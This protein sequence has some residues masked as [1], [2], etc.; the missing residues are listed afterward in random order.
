MRGME[1]KTVYT[2]SK[3][4]EIVALAQDSFLSLLSESEP[5]VTISPAKPETPEDITLDEVK[6]SAS[7]TQV[8]ITRTDEPRLSFTFTHPMICRA[9]D[10][11]IK[12][13]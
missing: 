8:V 5:L 13:R 6:V 9:F 7:L 1:H 2:Y 12:N 10:A 3:A 11:Y 4:P